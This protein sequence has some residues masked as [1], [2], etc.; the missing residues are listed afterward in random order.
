MRD[1]FK[2]W[3]NLPH[4]DQRIQVSDTYYHGSKCYECCP[5]VGDIVRNKFKGKPLFWNVRENRQGTFIQSDESCDIAK[6]VKF[7][8]IFEYFFFHQENG[9]PPR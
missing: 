1:Q 2:T 8:V 5:T 4:S 6:Y 7:S 9:I 3:I